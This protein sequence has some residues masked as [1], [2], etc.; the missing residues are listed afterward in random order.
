MAPENPSGTRSGLHYARMAQGADLTSLLQQWS[1]GEAAALEQLAPLVQRD[2]RDLARRLLDEER[3]T[4]RMQPTELV[5]ESYL[6]LLDWQSVHWQNRAHF[7]ATAAQM[8]RRILVSAARARR[9]E[10][11]G[12]GAAAVAF[13]EQRVAALPNVDVVAL[14][15]A[16]DALAALNPRPARVVEFR[17]FGGFSVE[18]TAAALDLSVRTVINDWNTARAWLRGELTKQGSNGR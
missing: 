18:E 7:F 8:M 5:H 10:K 12:S 14:C 13:D 4:G 6:R 9:A 3:R 1:R 11:R 15:D 16:L 2:L 17:F